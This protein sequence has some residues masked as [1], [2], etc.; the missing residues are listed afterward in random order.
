MVGVIWRVG[1]CTEINLKDGCQRD[2]RAITI[3]DETEH[4][5]D[6]TVWGE[7]AQSNDFR[8]GAIIAFKNCRVSEFSG[9]SLNASSDK[10]DIV[11]KVTHPIVKVI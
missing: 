6:V 9:R 4:S 11:F 2:K 8:E 7:Q 10:T 1:Q 3:V 5:I